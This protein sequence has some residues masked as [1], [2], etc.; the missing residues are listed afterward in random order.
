MDRASDL[1]YR[2]L[3]QFAQNLVCT[4]S[5]YTRFR[6][7]FT[8]H[9][10]DKV[11]E[12]EESVA[13][14]LERL[15]ELQRTR[16]DLL[17]TRAR[18]HV[19][20]YR[21]LPEPSKTQDPFRAI[22]ETLAS[23][24]PLE[25][26][27]YGDEPR[28]F[29]AR[30]SL[31]RRLIRGQTSGTTGTSL[32]LWCVPET[33]V[34][35][36]ATVWRMRRSFGVMDPVRPNLTFNGNIIVPFNQSRPPFWRSSFYD[37]RTLFS[38][39]HMTP[40]NL[41]SYADAVHAL[42]AEYVEGYPSAI[43][44]MARALLETGQPV[45]P[46]RIKAVFTSS[47]SLLSFQ[48][49]TIEKAFGAPVRDRYGASEN[50]VSMTECREGRLHVDLE[51]C[52]VEVET[53][54]ETDDF[55]TGP[56]LVTGLSNHATPLFRYRIGDVGTRSKHPCPCGRA[57]DVFFHVDGRVEDY[58][59]TPDGRLVGRLDHIFKEQFDVAEAQIIQTSETSISVLVV[60]RSTY[61]SAS[62]RALM[63]EIRA[64]LGTKMKIE[65]EIK[66]SIPREANGKF[67]AV[68]S[69]FGCIHA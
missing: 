36:F 33:L 57:G 24:P 30:D 68:K 40:E 17:L 48:R 49:E 59:L 42:P 63:R 54:S 22:Q 7:R 66:D 35:E 25:K 27:D 67:R 47:E 60:P 12:W 46:G 61:S 9:F 29:I 39:Y 52:I 65:I 62:S 56:L 10:N 55:E 45:A 13:W 8:Q 43:H 53:A 1:V 51:Y 50:V 44:L 69:E 38:V 23:I 6:A 31:R 15:H 3:P 18:E 20:Y 32:P 21:D 64:R 26:A 5:G 11:A 14:P 28:S 58:I 4:A 2:A 19:P 37:H 34:E 41:R 16:L